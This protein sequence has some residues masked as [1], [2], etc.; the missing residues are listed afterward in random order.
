MK[1]INRLVNRKFADIKYS[2]GDTIRDGPY[3]SG[4]LLNYPTKL[5]REPIR[6]YDPWHSRSMT[7]DAEKLK[8]KAI[9]SV[10]DQRK[11]YSEE[12]T[13]WNLYRGDFPAIMWVI[14]PYSMYHRERINYISKSTQV[15][16]RRKK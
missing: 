5:L 10:L 14:R 1:S 3:I 2:L 11:L 12:Y 13:S 8:I 15:P 9:R 7:M 4:K 16:P 6:L